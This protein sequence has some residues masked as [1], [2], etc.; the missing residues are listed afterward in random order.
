MSAAAGERAS[1]RVV[2]QGPIG[3]LRSGASV[4]FNG[5]RVGEVTELSLDPN[6]PKQA[7]ATISIDTD[8]PVRADTRGQSRLRRV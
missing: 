4:M 2:F 7:L 5:I 6:D 8:T 3:G 1:Y